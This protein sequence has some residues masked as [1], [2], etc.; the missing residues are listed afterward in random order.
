MSGVSEAQS[1]DVICWG[2]QLVSLR[3][4]SQS[5]SW[6]VLLGTSLEPLLGCAG[7]FLLSSGGGHVEYTFQI[8]CVMQP[9]VSHLCLPW[10]SVFQFSCGECVLRLTFVSVG[11]TFPCSEAGVCLSGSPGLLVTNYIEIS[12]IMGLDE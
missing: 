12:V 5:P 11:D 7:H 2:T 3:W 6:P 10:L 9:L 1:N 8:F 4:L